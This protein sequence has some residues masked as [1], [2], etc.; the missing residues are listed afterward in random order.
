MEEISR[1]EE[2][3]KKL[4]HKFGTKPQSP[5]Q[6]INSWNIWVSAG[7]PPSHKLAQNVFSPMVGWAD[8]LWI[9]MQ[10]NCVHAL[11]KYKLRKKKATL[12]LFGDKAAKPLNHYFK[13]WLSLLALRQ[14]FQKNCPNIC[15][16]PLPRQ[17]S[18]GRMCRVRMCRRSDW[19]KAGQVSE[20]ALKSALRIFYL[21]FCVCLNFIHFLNFSQENWR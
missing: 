2:S 15:P 12:T 5:K 18:S 6:P 16:E 17:M 11:Q 9:E 19:R 10:W 20:S 8:G 7:I 21:I 3:W 4:W 1:T 14:G 13:L